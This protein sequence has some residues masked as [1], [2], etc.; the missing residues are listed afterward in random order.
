MSNE[1][2]AILESLV[3]RMLKHFGPLD[4][5]N[6]KLLLNVRSSKEVEAYLQFKVLA[7]LVIDMDG[8][9]SSNKVSSREALEALFKF[10]ISEAER[11]LVTAE[12]FSVRFGRVVASLLNQG[13][14]RFDL[15]WNIVPVKGR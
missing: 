11:A 8:N 9:L 12:N 2:Y 15:D 6:L 13:V 4:A 1:V 14:F 3:R 5:K 7:V 10:K